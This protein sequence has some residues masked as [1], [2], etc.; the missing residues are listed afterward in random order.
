MVGAYLLGGTLAV[1]GG[2]GCLLASLITMLPRILLLNVKLP[3]MV[4]ANKKAEQ[5][6][7]PIANA[8]TKI[9]TTAKKI[10]SKT[11]EISNHCQDNQTGQQKLQKELKELEDEQFDNTTQLESLSRQRNIAFKHFNRIEKVDRGVAHAAGIISAPVS[12]L[13]L[14]IAKFGIFI[15][16]KADSHSE[17]NV[18]FTNLK[19]LVE[20]T[21]KSIG[22]TAML[23]KQPPIGTALKGAIYEVSETLMQNKNQQ[24]IAPKPKEL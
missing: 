3:I 4:V 2:A 12:L 17:H 7:G 5:F 8:K 23:D 18:H 10:E 19:K 14:A 16:E 24:S 22:E 1:I 11:L 20:A 9:D 21:I 15:I 13:S 6:D